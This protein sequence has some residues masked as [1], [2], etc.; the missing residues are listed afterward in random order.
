MTDGVECPTCGRDGFDSPRAMRIH[1][2][3]AHGESIAKTYEKTCAMCGDGFTVKAGSKTQKYCSVDCQDAARRERITLQCEVCGDAFESIPSNA[4]RRRTCSQQCMGKLTAD[5]V[6]LSCAHCG[7]VYTDHPSRRGVR[8][9]CSHECLTEDQKNRVEVTCEYCGDAYEVK[10]YRTEETRYC[11]RECQHEGLSA[12]AEW[13]TVEC[14]CGRKFRALVSEE[15]KYCTTHCRAEVLRDPESRP[16]TL[17]ELLVDLYDHQEQTL[18]QTYKRANV[19]LTQ[20]DHYDNDSIKQRHVRRLLR[21]F[22]VY[23]PG[24]KNSDSE[25]MKLVHKLKDQT[26]PNETA[27]ANADSWRQYYQEAD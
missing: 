23:V 17:R 12:R 8:T 24:L 22:G 4:E 3:K 27:D 16:D 14:V 13:E 10:K 21:I 7:D 9:Y 19:A 6:E 2:T 25:K 26:P 5:P 15:R 20:S 1:H 11:S 18:R